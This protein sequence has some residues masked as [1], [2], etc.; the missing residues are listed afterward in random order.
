[1]WCTCIANLNLSIYLSNKQTKKQ[2]KN[3]VKQQYLQ[4]NKTCERVNK[5]FEKYPFYDI[6]LFTYVIALTK[7][8]H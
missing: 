2:T 7:Y 1:M 4:L 3:K 8:E 6:V 5:T